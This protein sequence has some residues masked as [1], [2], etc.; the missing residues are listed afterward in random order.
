MARN[1]GKFQWVTC[2]PKCGGRTHWEKLTILERR[3]AGYTESLTGYWFCEECLSKDTRLPQER[4]PADFYT[5]TDSN[6]A[7]VGLAGG[8]LK[9][10]HKKE[11]SL[12]FM[13]EEGGNL[14]SHPSSMSA[15]GQWYTEKK[16]M[17][18]KTKIENYRGWLSTNP[19]SGTPHRT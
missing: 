17:D 8:T 6:A 13:I 15:W 4:Y 5:C 2:C 12:G 1:N 18:R 14:I 10:L 9:R 7:V 11:P 16:S 3:E 19:R